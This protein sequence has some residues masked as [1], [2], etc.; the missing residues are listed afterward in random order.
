VVIDT[1]VD[2]IHARGTCIRADDVPLPLRAP[3]AGPPDAPSVISDV[4]AAIRR[5]PSPRG[6]SVAAAAPSA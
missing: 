4:G 5:L 2:G 1:G 6:G 3:L